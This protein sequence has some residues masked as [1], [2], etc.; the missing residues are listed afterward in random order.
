MELELDDPEGKPLLRQRVQDTQA[1]LRVDAP[2]L[3]TAETPDLYT[4]RLRA[5]GETIAQRVGLRTIEIRDGLVLLNGQRVFMHGVNRH[6]SDPQT[7]YAVSR[8][9][10]LR[11]MRLMKEHNINAIRTSHYPN[12]PCF[13]ELAD[14]YGFYVIGEAD[15][16]S[17]GTRALY[18][19]KGSMSLLMR[20]PDYREAV[21]DRVQRGVIPH[22]NHACVLLW[23]MGNESGYGENIEEALRWT[24]A[25][26]PTRLTHY[27]SYVFCPEDYTPEDGLMD[28]Y[29]RMYPPIEQID[30]YFDREHADAETLALA[31]RPGKSDSR[32]PYVLCE[33]CHAMGNGPGDLEDYATLLPPAS[34]NLRRLCLGVVR[35]CGV[36]GPHG[37][38]V[39]PST[40]YGGDFGEV[41][42]DGNFCMDG[43][44]LPDRRISTSLEEL[45]NVLR[46]IR[47]CGMSPDGQGVLLQSQ[48][49][50]VD[51]GEH[52][53]LRWELARDGV[54]VAQGETGPAV[55]ASPGNGDGLPAAAGM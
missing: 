10:I 1:I 36:R 22:A 21:L 53:Q 9:H 2:L 47:A 41:F 39:N 19:E 7:G 20:D 13:Y 50:F 51:A 37:Q 14:E 25:Y 45:S 6:D 17:H 43:L 26:D 34:G 18:G 40:C 33:Y 52:Y 3:W 55:H 48:L 44:V 28:V 16:E 15:L 31:L 5:A 42:S 27:E 8:E 30:A 35:P 54:T 38:P 24:R 11:D 32:K 29:S 4:L 49:D 46:P 23:S 12:A